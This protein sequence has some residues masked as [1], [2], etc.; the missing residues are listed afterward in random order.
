MGEKTKKLCD[1]FMY[2]AEAQIEEG[3]IDQA[4]SFFVQ[5]VQRRDPLQKRLP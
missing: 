5:Q 1:G 2:L 3:N 4:K